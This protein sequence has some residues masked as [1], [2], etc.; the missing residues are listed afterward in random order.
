M[1]N[2]T[3]IL[4]LFSFMYAC[5]SSSSSEGNQIDASAGFNGEHSFLKTLEGEPMKVDGEII[6]KMI[7]STKLS[8]TIIGTDVVGTYD[9][10]PAEK[11]ATRGQVKGTIN[12]YGKIK[13]TYNFTQESEKGSQEIIIELIGD[14]AIISGDPEDI[15]FSKIS[16]SPLNQEDKYSG[17]YQNTLNDEGN[18]FGEVTIRNLSPSELSF[19]IMTGNKDGCT[20][21]ISGR[22]IVQSDQTI[23]YSDPD[24][25]KLSFKFTDQGITITE[26][27]CTLHGIKCSFSGEYIK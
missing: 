15:F 1:K 11:D 27:K 17:T 25:E 24:C 12:E 4:C 13:A 16:Y 14:G 6:Q 22:A 2:L 20:G 7:D 8:L 23:S 19:Q 9:Y 18:F 5:N 10:L 26:E 21:Q 3:L